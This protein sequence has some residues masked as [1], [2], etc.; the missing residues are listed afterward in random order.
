MG[1][2]LHRRISALED[3]V[4]EKLS[5]LKAMEEMTKGVTQTLRMHL[6]EHFVDIDSKIKDV[7]HLLQQADTK[8][9]ELVGMGRIGRVNMVS[10]C[11]AFGA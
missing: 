3:R 4:V 11:K 5:P 2:S 6:T 1:E 9:L 7:G 8:V 10:R